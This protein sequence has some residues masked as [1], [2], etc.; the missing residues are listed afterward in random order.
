MNDN[1]CYD[2]SRIILNQYAETVSIARF[3]VDGQN[4]RMF[5]IFEMQTILIT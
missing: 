1:I 3:L 5:V 2:R 4:T